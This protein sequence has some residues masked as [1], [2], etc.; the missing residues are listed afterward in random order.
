MAT[1]FKK[2]DEIEAEEGTL[3]TVPVQPDDRKDHGPNNNNAYT[4]D[5][6]YNEK[7]KK[8]KVKVGEDARVVQ[9]PV[10]EAH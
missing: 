6:G 5:P 9:N 3:N 7:G 2:G 1:N 8:L 4:P 10:E